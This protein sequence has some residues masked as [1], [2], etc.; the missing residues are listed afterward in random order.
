MYQAPL[1]VQCDL[2]K[3]YVTNMNKGIWLKLLFV[4][5]QYF[6]FF[7]HVTLICSPC[8]GCCQKREGRLKPLEGKEKRKFKERLNVHVMNMLQRRSTEIKQNNKI[9]M[10]TI[11]I[12]QI[13]PGLKA[14][15]QLVNLTF[16]SRYTCKLSTNQLTGEP[17]IDFTLAAILNSSNVSCI[18]LKKISYKSR[19]S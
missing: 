17:S 2:V 6:L 11:R 7:T 3:I 13:Q 5:L 18:A 1:I 14:Q 19:K 16:K 12:M 10:H 9:N 8:D 15:Y 4:A